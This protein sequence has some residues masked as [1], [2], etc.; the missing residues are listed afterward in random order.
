MFVFVF[1]NFSSSI[2]V[3]LQPGG[4]GGGVFL[5][6]A[7]LIDIDGTVDVSGNDSLTGSGG[8]SGGSI[9]VLADLFLGKGQL[10]CNGG[11]AANN[12]GGASGGRISIHCN[13]CEFTG[14][15]SAQGGASSAEPGG[16]GTVYQQTETG[17][18]SKRTLTINNGG[19]L[20]VN[21]YLISG[22]HYENS[23]KA[24]VLI[25]TV[26]D[27]IYDE[28]R[29]LGGAHVSFVL[30]VEGDV[31]IKKLFGDGTGMLHVQTN[32]RVAIKSAATE[33]PS[34]FR[35]YEGG[36]FSLPDT[37]HLNKFTHSQLYIEGKLGY[38][39]DFRVG[40]GVTVSLGNKVCN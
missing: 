20:P 29:L 16:A 14:K 11:K 27:L 3:S 8:G 21:S 6:R 30:S 1:F 25:P 32:D 24:W 22:N 12:G 36:F 31:S 9:H 26:D 23:G 18:K 17:N 15:I 37:V 33:F 2:D 34:W 39:K 19:L 38:V 10:V 35:V 5:L 40:T 13:R 7:E 4:A 28:F